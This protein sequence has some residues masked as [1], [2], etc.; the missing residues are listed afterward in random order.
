MIVTSRS[1]A[2]PFNELYSLEKAGQHPVLAYSTGRPLYL[3]SDDLAAEIA[4]QTE[5]YRGFPEA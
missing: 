2:R 1:A 3:L 5:A 4:G